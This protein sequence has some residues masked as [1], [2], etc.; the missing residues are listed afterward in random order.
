[1]KFTGKVNNGKL[2]LDD[3]EMFRQ[4]LFNFDGYVSIEI[5]AAE[6]V[7]SPQQNAYYRVIVRVLGK[8]L[9]YTQD[10]MHKVLKD[11][12]ELESTK[13]LSVQEFGEYIDQV[14]RWAVTEMGIVLPDPKQVHQ[15]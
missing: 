6:K 5:K 11:K 2:T 1:M 12:Y 4:Y 9:G 15:L 14:I 3:K 13:G 10:E 8:E 7:R